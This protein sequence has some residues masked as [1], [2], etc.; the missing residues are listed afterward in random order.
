MTNHLPFE[1]TLEELRSELKIAIDAAN[2]ACMEYEVAREIIAEKLKS[3]LDA[4]YEKSAKL[5]KVRQRVEYL[6][7]KEDCEC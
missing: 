3:F 5:I 7:Q 4:E 1:K 6:D 2:K